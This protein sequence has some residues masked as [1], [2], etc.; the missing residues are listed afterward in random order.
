M[1]GYGA[2]S[3]GQGQGGGGAVRGQASEGLDG[4]EELG[5]RASLGGEQVALR[6]FAVQHVG[7][8]AVMWGLQGETRCSIWEMGEDMQ[9]F[10]GSGCSRISER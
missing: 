4:T 9:A 2:G 5:G 7:R 6:S 10:E 3:E 8:Y 1:A